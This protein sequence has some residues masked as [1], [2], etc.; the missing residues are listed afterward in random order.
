MT[1]PPV[2]AVGTPSSGV[3]KSR[4][5]RLRVHGDVSVHGPSRHFTLSR[6]NMV[7]EHTDNGACKTVGSPPQGTGSDARRQE[8]PGAAATAPAHD[9]P[10]ELRASLD[11]VEAALPRFV[12]DGDRR[13]PRSWRSLEAMQECA[14]RLLSHVRDHAIGDRHPSHRETAGFR[15]RCRFGN[16]DALTGG[17]MEWHLSL[18]EELAR[19]IDAL[20]REVGQPRDDVVLQM[21]RAGLDRF[22]SP[23][24][25]Q[26]QG[27]SRRPSCAGRARRPSQEIWR[28]PTDWEIFDQLVL[29]AEGRAAAQPDVSRHELARALMVNVAESPADDPAGV[30]ERTLDHV[31]GPPG[32]EFARALPGGASH[33]PPSC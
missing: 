8:L 22:R 27:R 1:E 25:E 31:L 28:C 2:G 32:A 24:A 15:R 33:R 18:P 13:P 6:L 17:P 29:L 5:A 14:Y 21:L 26:S 3:S 12:P 10:A 16:G 7:E 9:A 11:N 30:V 20:A 4:W 19:G 23:Q